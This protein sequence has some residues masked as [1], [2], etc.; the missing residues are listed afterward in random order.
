MQKPHITLWK[1]GL[2]LCEADGWISA[3]LSPVNA[4]ERWQKFKT[5]M[6]RIQSK[7]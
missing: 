6:T 1:H 5:A 4:F 7:G 2:W 3:G